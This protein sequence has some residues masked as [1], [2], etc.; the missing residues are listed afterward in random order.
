LSYERQARALKGG[1]VLKYVIAVEMVLHIQ[2]PAATTGLKPR[3]E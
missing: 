2:K 1:G 3:C